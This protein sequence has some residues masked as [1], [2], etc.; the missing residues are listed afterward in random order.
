LKTEV[1][2]VF[3]S[4]VLLMLMRLSGVRVRKPVER[5]GSISCICAEYHEFIMA[6]ALVE[7]SV[8]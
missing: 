6:H 4:W 3:T 1:R 5:A 7:M 8:S 2:V